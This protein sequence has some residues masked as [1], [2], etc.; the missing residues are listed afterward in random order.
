MAQ[1][2]GF[3]DSAEL[4]AA[5][6]QLAAAKD[7]KV[8]RGRT[9]ELEQRVPFAAMRTIRPTTGTVAS[10]S[11]K[12]IPLA[13]PAPS[14]DKVEFSRELATSECF[15]TAAEAYCRAAGP[16]VVILDD[17][18][19]ADSSSL[20]TLRRLGEAAQ[21]IPLVIVVAVRPLP[22]ESEMSALLA[23]YASWGAEHLQLGPMS[24]PEV[25]AL[26][27]IALGSPAGPHLSA[28][29]SGAGGNP[30]YVIELLA[31]LMRGELIELGEITPESGDFTVGGSST[32]PLPRSLTDAIARRL[33]FLPLPARQILPMA[34]ALG[35]GVEAIE[36][37]TVLDAALIDVW[38]VIS[39]AFE[40]GLLVRAGD[41]LVFRHELIRQVLAEQLP[42]ST[43]ATLQRRAARILMSMEAPV[44]RIAAYLR[45]SDAPLDTNW[46]EWLIDVADTLMARAPQLA[47]IL[48]TRAK[49]T[50]GLDAE[51][52]S[53]LQVRHVRAL[54]CNGEAA[55][56]EAAAQRALAEDAAVAGR[57]DQTHDS[58]LWL[59]AHACFVQGRVSDALAV[60]ESATALHSARAGAPALPAGPVGRCHDRSAVLP[61]RTGRVRPAA[62]S[63]IF[64][65]PD[66]RSP[67]HLDN[68]SV[69]A[70]SEPS[71][72]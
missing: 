58:L 8:L 68:Y 5:L 21:R 17:A 30:L 3:G 61:S 66:R 60:A 34:A 63:G 46:L 49:A 41:E 48:L 35:P 11:G 2:R 1:H 40:A 25:A 7:V 14:T 32:L 26:V 51:R 6:A 39:A 53:A 67:R 64:C 45:A 20:F 55:Q 33:D 22:R 70:C 44:E 56:A 23:Q 10:S 18:Q 9:R 19:W 31:G 43:R 29:V 72:R 42:T 16:T 50:V 69:A 54:L 36:L 4:L 71:C 47:V 37:A 15:L 62:R 12:P 24:E 38:T 52:G 28:L 13:Y 65:R 59:L 27:E 57:P